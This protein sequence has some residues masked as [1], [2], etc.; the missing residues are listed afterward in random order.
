MANGLSFLCKIAGSSGV[1]GRRAISLEGLNLAFNCSGKVF[2][3]KPFEQSLDTR[4]WVGVASI[5]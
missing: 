5:L 1:E 4:I 3:T 2:G